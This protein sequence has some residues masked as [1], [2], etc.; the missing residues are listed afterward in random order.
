MPVSRRLAFGV[1]H[2]CV[3]VLFVW[4]LLGVVDLV[5]LV[6]VTLCSSRSLSIPTVDVDASDCG[7]ISQ[8]LFD[9]LKI[10][11]IKTNKCT[12]AFQLN[13]R[14]RSPKVYQEP[15]TKQVCTSR[16]PNTWYPLTAFTLKPPRSKA[17]QNS[18]REP[19]LTCTPRVRIHSP[20]ET[21]PQPPGA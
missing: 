8:L 9:S 1:G 21:A 2:A 11:H 14:L 3:L 7:N 10:K 13:P 19:Q 6:N 16:R 5:R 20:G 12:P 17:S 18:N 4:V 15:P